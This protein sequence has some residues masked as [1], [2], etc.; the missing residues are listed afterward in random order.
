MIPFCRRHISKQ[1]LRPPPCPCCTCWYWHFPACKAF[2]SYWECLEAPGVCCAVCQIGSR[3][4]R[5][6]PAG[7]WAEQPTRCIWTAVGFL[8]YVYCH[9]FY[10]YFYLFSPTRSTAYWRVF[11]KILKE[12]FLM[13]ELMGFFLLFQF[14][15][16]KIVPNWKTP[17]LS[18]QKTTAALTKLWDMLVSLPYCHSRVFTHLLIFPWVYPSD[19]KNSILW[20]LGTR[21]GAV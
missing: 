4:D 13:T 19:L 21:K 2:C 7:K 14:L 11:C 3:S 1:Q 6:A 12:I 15:P 5:G 20:L 16:W 17:S 9:C 8:C 10:F 18:L